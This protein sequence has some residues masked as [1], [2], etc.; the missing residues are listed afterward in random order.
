MHTHR[1]LLLLLVVARHSGRARTLLA[2]GDGTGYCP[3][4]QA[5]LAVDDSM[6]LSQ[7]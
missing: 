3:G 5:W 6:G 7:H 1:E 4:S 2:V